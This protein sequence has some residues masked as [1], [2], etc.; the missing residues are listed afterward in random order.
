M[1]I[2]PMAIIDPKAKLA[3][4]LEVGAHSFIG[5]NVEI[6][7]GCKIGIN[8][9]IDGNTTVGKNCRI[10]TGVVL[11][12]APQD[13]KFKG[14]KSFLRVGSDNII[15]EYCTL[16]MGTGEGGVTQVGDGNLLMAY[17]HIAH[18][19]FLGNNCIIANCGTL[20]GHVTIEDR[21][22]V[23]GLVAIHQF[24]R[25]GQISIVGGCSKVVQDIP[26]FSTCDGHPTKVYGLNLIG[27]QRA[28]IS[29]ENIKGLKQA[30]KI[31]FR[32]GLTIS[33]AVEE[34]KKEIAPSEQIDHLINFIETSER[35]I[36]R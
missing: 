23:G 24:V 17:S 15:R 30:F 3:A 2:H 28:G 13:L 12:S 1:K 20:A 8:C 7:T 26:P 36:C 4:D 31:L 21:A 6:G 25:M 34:I 11:G 9:V 35:G 33:H 27:L 18:D 22:V 32:K 19:C 10:F 14:E 29:E 5:A 16:N